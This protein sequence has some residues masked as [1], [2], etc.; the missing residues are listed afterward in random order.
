MEHNQP[1]AGLAEVMSYLGIE[2]P[3]FDI[4]RIHENEVEI[5]LQLKSSGQIHIVRVHRSFLEHTFEDEIG[6]RLTNFRLAPVLRDLG[7]LP[8]ALTPSGCIF[9]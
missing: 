5:V 9:M 7:N 4:A 8:V 3:H 1:E 6:E 2:F